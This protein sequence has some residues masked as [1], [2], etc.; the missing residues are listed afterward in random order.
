MRK[1]FI[2]LLLFPL[3]GLSQTGI[4]TCGF[5]CGVTGTVGQHFNITGTGSISTST[6]R[7]GAR[8]F[9]SNP[10]AASG[11][12]VST[13]LTNSSVW[14]I[15]SYVYFATLP[16]GNSSLI[17]VPINNGSI[18][19][20]GAVY[21]SSDA[22]IYAGIANGAAFGATGVSVTT[23][24]WY[25]V[26]VKINASI[27][28]WTIDVQ[29]NTSACAQRTN[30]V[31]S[32]SSTTFEVGNNATVTADVF[33]DDIF[34]SQT[35]GNYPIGAGYVNH[36]IPT[37]DGTHNVAGTNDFERTLT[38]TDIDNTTT[39]AYQLID[40][41]P[42]ESS[43][44]DFINMILPINAT[45]YTEH[46]FGAAAG[47]STPTAA[48]RAVEVIAAIHQTGTGTGN[49]EIRLNDNGSMGTVYTATT[50]AG[51]T[52]LVYKRAHFVDPPSAA[53]VWTLS[54]NGNFNNIKVRFGSPAALDVNPDQ[55]LDCIMVEA[56]FLEVPLTVPGTPGDKRHTTL[57]V[58]VAYSQNI[59][60][61]TKSF[62]YTTDSILFRP[63]SISYDTASMLSK[64]FNHL[65]YSTKK[66]TK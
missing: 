24:Q 21:R 19:Y 29:V 7:N 1:L 13:T 53:S 66:I 31:A 58:G 38:G 16:S 25:L 49:M 9:R 65:L 11:N 56:E 12:A 41:V 40:D 46:V 14:I 48:P 28:P 39:T 45:D 64:N 37:S 18:T 59:F 60:N 62:T 43:V 22:S 2:I 10:S 33:F 8:S 23:G 32:G 26:D 42:M 4:F 35:S 57:G 54:G 50:V 36:F 17:H 47:I 3:F 6:V 5:E 55:Y 44:V 51:T 27:N 34:I 15:R 63:V 20:V 30:A 61:T 52:T